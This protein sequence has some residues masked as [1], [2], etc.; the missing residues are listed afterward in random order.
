MELM[1]DDAGKVYLPASDFYKD[2]I[3]DQ[4]KLG[5]KLGKEK[6]DEIQY[7]LFITLNESDCFKRLEKSFQKEV[8][9][10]FKIPYEVIKESV[11]S[12]EEPKEEITEYPKLKLVK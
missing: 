3:R 12:T 11:E 9:L 2:F 4:L 5:A 6:Y 10:L 8:F 7:H 1:H